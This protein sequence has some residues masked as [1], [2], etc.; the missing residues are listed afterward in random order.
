[1]AA[2]LKILATWDDEAQVWVAESD[3]VPGL[4]AEAESIPALLA[5]LK[6]LVPEMLEENGL[7]NESNGE[8]PFELVASVSTTA[9]NLTHQ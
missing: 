6:V 3:D 5:K 9:P 7:P 2:K 1:M 8:I 4:V